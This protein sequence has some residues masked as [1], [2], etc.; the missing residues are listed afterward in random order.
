MISMIHRDRAFSAILSDGKIA[1]VKV[2]EKDRSYWTLPGGGVEKGESREKAAV[3]EA[4]EEINLKIKIVRFLFSGKYPAGIEYCYLAEPLNGE[5]RIKLGRDPE[6]GAGEQ[7][8]KRA[9][10]V[11]I[12]NLHDD[13]HVSQVLRSLSR[14]EIV[15]Y[16]I[17]L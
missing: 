3:R 16:K 6:L 15:K 14:E 12:V 1:L 10:W 8:L 9:E 17:Y 13:L 11:P 4:L 7:V 2:E 5:Q